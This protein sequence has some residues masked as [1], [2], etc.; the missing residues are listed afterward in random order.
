MGREAWKLGSGMADDIDFFITKGRFG[1]LANYMQ[2]TRPMLIWEGHSP[3]DESVTEVGFSIGEDWTIVGNGDSVISTK[4]RKT[5]VHTTIA[6]RMVSRL[7]DSLGTIPDGAPVEPGEYTEKVNDKTFRNRWWL[8]PLLDG[9][10]L[11]PHIWEGYAFHLVRERVEYKGLHRDGKPAAGAQQ[12]QSENVTTNPLMPVAF[13]SYRGQ[14]AP[15]VSA[16]AAAAATATA[17]SAPAAASA[18]ATSTASTNGAANGLAHK[19]LQLL[20]TKHTDRQQFQLEAMDVR[21]VAQD[22]ALMA[23]VMDDGP[24]GYWATN[25]K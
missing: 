21:E 9:N 16:P 23:H 24:S 3:D 7:I 13:L 20:L 8:R 12:G 19:K 17:S 11:D 18:P 6:G 2:G 1:F 25:K 10:Q 4:N 22:D 14:T 15:D 5:F